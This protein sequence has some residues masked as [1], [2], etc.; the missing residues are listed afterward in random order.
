MSELEPK[1][2]ESIVLSITQELLNAIDN[3][4]INTP[5]IK[6]FEKKLIER[7]RDEL[8]GMQPPYVIDE[9]YAI[10]D[11]ISQGRIHPES[12]GS[13]KDSMK[14]LESLNSEI[15]KTFKSKLVEKL[16]EARNNKDKILNQ[17][18]NGDNDKFEEQNR[19]LF[20]MVN[21]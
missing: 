13:L 6:M 9:I 19:Q 15:I 21:R 4:T 17:E 20:D 10:I 14:E 18:E 8:E 11:K 1:E 7:I 12:A 5:F 2:W 3:T 16:E